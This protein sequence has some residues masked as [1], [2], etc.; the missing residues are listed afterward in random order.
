MTCLE[1]GAPMKVD[2]S[3][4]VVPYTLAGLPQVLLY[5]VEV[6][7]CANGHEETAIPRIAQLHRLIASLLV[8]K[9][10]RLAPEEI[11][12]LRKHLGYSQADFARRMGVAPE[13][14]SRWET[15]AIAMKPT[16][17]NLLRLMVVTQAPI[18][19]YSLDTLA[20]VTGRPKPIAMKLKSTKD[21]WQAA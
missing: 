9:P 3:R 4:G 15:G 16:A 20:R 5:G 12:F 11:R 18:R 14:V 6:R 1:C 7:R 17:E 19:D 10:A 21:T 2:R 8:R 13:S